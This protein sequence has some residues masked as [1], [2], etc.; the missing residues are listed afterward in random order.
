M[1]IHYSHNFWVINI[2][3]SLCS[4]VATGLHRILKILS[5]AVEKLEEG[6]TTYLETMQRTAELQ[7]GRTVWS[8]VA[9]IIDSKLSVLALNLKSSLVARKVFL[10][11]K[12]YFFF[13]LQSRCALITY[14]IMFI[15]LSEFFSLKL[16][17]YNLALTDDLTDLTDDAT[18]WGLGVSLWVSKVLGILKTIFFDSR[19]FFIKFHD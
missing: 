7:F 4:A 19:I 6:Q 9:C 2:A 16:K 17:E 15:V 14:N 1:H 8:W 18:V 13:F 5:P 11:S 12:W 10:W 3:E